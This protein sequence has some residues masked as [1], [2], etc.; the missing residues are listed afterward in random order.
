M[1]FLD[2]ADS[3]GVLEPQT[4]TPRS[5]TSLVQ[6]EV[7]LKDGYALGSQLLSRV[8]ILLDISE[9]RSSIASIVFNSKS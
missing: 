6:I 4:P 5:V 3:L 9:I 2:R 8:S 7:P 1:Q